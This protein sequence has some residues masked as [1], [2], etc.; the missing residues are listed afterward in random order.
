MRRRLHRIVVP[1]VLVGLLPGACSEEGRER[2]RGRFLGRFG[3]R[4]PRSRPSSPGASVGSA[5][6]ATVTLDVAS[7]TLPWSVSS[8]GPSAAVV[9]IGRFDAPMSRAGWSWRSSGSSGESKNRGPRSHHLRRPE[10]PE[11]TQPLKEKPSKLPTGGPTGTTAQVRERSQPPDP[12]PR[13]VAPLRTG[14]TMMRHPAL[15]TRSSLPGGEP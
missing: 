7:G 3:D 9:G 4:R 5:V 2:I 14:A 6:G 8:E 13:C 15:R 11:P 10:A 12:T 1:F